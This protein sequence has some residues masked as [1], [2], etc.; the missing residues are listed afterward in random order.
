M[1]SKERREKIYR[2]N[3]KKSGELWEK[4][5]KNDTL[6]NHRAFFDFFPNLDKSYLDWQ[7]GVDYVYKDE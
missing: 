2:E 6:E 5:K 3:C 1:T 7:E 4:I